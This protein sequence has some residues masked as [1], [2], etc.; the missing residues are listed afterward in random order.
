MAS[1]KKWQ[2]ENDGAGHVHKASAWSSLHGDNHARGHKERR[3]NEPCVGLEGPVGALL[4]EWSLGTSWRPANNWS[5]DDK[6]YSAWAKPA[7]K[8]KKRKQVAKVIRKSDKAYRGKSYRIACIDKVRS[9]ASW[10]LDIGFKALKQDED[11]GYRYGS[12]LACFGP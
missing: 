12:C 7:E 9:A 1:L 3:R 11:L 2:N 10:G 8:R 4:E 6:G 5:V